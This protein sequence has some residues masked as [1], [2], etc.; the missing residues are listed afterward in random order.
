[1]SWHCVMSFLCVWV[2]VCVCVCVCKFV[3]LVYAGLHNELVT[4]IKS[5]KSQHVSLKEVPLF[6]CFREIQGF[7]CGS[8]G[9]DS[10]CSE[11]DLGSI[12]G[13]GRSPGEGK[14]Y[15]FQYSGLEDS[16]DCIVHGVEKSRT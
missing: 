3:A 16:M 10:L 7:P 2:C 11:G 6:P 12:P 4:C 14:G 9:K 5:F 15:P 1:M 13:L 8:A